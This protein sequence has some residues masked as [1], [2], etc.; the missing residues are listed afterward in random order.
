MTEAEWLA[1]T[2]T[3]AMLAHLDRP[4]PDR[5]IRLYDIACCRDLKQL[6]PEQASLDGLDWA[7]RFADG[8]ASRDEAY[9]K[10][11]N[12]SEGA[13]LNYSTFYC[14]KRDSLFEEDGEKRKNKQFEEVAWFAYYVM[15]YES[16]M[17]DYSNFADHRNLLS[18]RQ[19]HEVFGNPFRPVTLNPSRLTSTVLD[20]AT[21]IYADGAFDLMPILADALQDAGCDNEDILN[22]CRQPGDHCRGCWVVD[23]L[24]V[25]G[26][27]PHCCSD[28]Q[29]WR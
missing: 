24:T 13:Y 16:F 3:V 2:D 9:D 4:K 7:E 19:V 8:S 27:N 11:K 25:G 18:V 5:R 26:K 14:F 20:L 17:P 21:G 15:H 23:L 22:H 28:Q 10:I 12:A 1:A 6:L 29:Q